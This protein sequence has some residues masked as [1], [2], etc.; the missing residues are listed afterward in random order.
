MQVNASVAAQ[1]ITFAST[2]GG[3]PYTNLVSPTSSPTALTPASGVA[4]LVRNAD[5]TL[6]YVLAIETSP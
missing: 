3:Q 2:L 4:L 1:S 6:D 5:V